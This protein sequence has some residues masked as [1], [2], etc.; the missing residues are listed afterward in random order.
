MVLGVASKE[1][2]STFAHA[3]LKQKNGAIRRALVVCGAEG[4]DEF[5]CA[6]ST[7]VWT[8]D[9][10]A[11]TVTESTVTPEDFG[12]PVHSLSTV[13]GHSAKENAE[14]LKTLLKPGYTSANREVPIDIGPVRDFVLLNASALLVVSGVASDWK[15]GV[16][17]ARTS[18]E[19]GRAWEAIEAFRVSSTTA[20]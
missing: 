6:G 5:S 13:I 19:N 3:L 14:V 16:Q 11:G 7:H 17:R 20:A 1:L 4:L 2:G 18:I 8:V 10:A 15:D 12:L 9:S